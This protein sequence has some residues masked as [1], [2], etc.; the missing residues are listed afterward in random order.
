MF[1]RFKQKVDMKKSA[2][3]NRWSEW[4]EPKTFQF[5]KHQVQIRL[6]KKTAEECIV[7]FLDICSANI[8]DHIIDA[9]IYHEAFAY[10]VDEVEIIMEVLDDEAAPI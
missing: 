10:V 8:A 7:V 5:L 9:D 6:P 4:H 2:G 3:E 1:Y